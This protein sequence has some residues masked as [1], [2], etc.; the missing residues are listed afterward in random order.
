MAIFAVLVSVAVY[1]IFDIEY[2]RIGLLRI[3]VADNAM[4][5]LRSSMQ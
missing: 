2:P 5:S 3:G 1:I 4:T